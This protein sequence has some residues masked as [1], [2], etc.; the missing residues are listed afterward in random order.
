MND[1]PEERASMLGE[2]IV[3]NKATVRAA[4][5][6]FG[7]SKS[8]VH[9]DVTDRLRSSDPALYIQ[10]RQVLDLNK[11]QRHLRGGMA[12]KEKY[13]KEKIKSV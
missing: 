4:A 12:T 13:R 11:A 8:T 6:V 9:T 2:Y 5:K 1:Y 3:K 10:V 7:I